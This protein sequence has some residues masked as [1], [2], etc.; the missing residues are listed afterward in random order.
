MN[1]DGLTPMARDHKALVRGVAQSAG[2]QVQEDGDLSHLVVP[3][4]PIR[5]QTVLVNFAAKDTEGHA[6]IGYS[7]VCGPSSPEN[8]ML[9]LKF[10]QQMVHGAF[11]V[12]GSPSGDLVVVQ[13]NQL[14]ET[15]D[16]FSINRVVS[17]VAWQADKA[18][19]KL[20]GG[21]AH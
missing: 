11:A 17:A 9:L 15:A 12:Q 2:W 19:E 7:S 3:I 18:E 10:N 8:A 5:K 21:D 20:T 6:V 14:V 4:G 16:P 13:A 1:F